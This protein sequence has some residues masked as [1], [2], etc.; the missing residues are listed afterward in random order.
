[1]P[2]DWWQVKLE[3]FIFIMENMNFLFAYIACI[4]YLGVV[5]MFGV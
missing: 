2:S 3:F 5:P 1:M 4:W